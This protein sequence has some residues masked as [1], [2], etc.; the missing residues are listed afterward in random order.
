MKNGIILFSI[1]IL[2]L[3]L[4]FSVAQ[5][6]D[7]IL[8]QVNESNTKSE[9]IK[10]SGETS[11][12]GK[13]FFLTAPSG[14]IFTINKDA[15]KFEDDSVFVKINSAVKIIHSSKTETIDNIDCSCPVKILATNRE[16]RIPK[17]GC[18][19]KCWGVVLFCTDCVYNPA[20]V[21]IKEETKVCGACIGLP[22]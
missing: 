12:K 6:S 10:F 3:N 1:V 19:T 16:E 8:S 21:F 9:W 15:V 13:K 17:H 4:T 2:I 18:D 7:T 5:T 11:K 22:F 20:G 14:D